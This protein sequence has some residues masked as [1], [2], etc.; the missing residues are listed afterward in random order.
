MNKL[1]LYQTLKLFHKEFKTKREQ[2]Y[3][4]IRWASE[5]G[6]IDILNWWSFS[7]SNFK[8]S[9]G[10]MNCASTNGH[11]DYASRNGHINVLTS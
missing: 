3:I 8:Y 4:L 11:I 6:F 2:N 9:D 7:N 10:A 5:Y 1:E